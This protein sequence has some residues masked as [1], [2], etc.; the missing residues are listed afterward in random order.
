MV[1]T[2]TMAT[3]SDVPEFDPQRYPPF[4]SDIPTAP[5]KKISLAKLLS[6]DTAEIDAL[7]EACKTYGFFYLSTRDHPQGEALEQGSLN[8][9]RIAEET[10]KLPLEE[11]KKCSMQNTGTIFGYKH[12]GGSKTD[13]SGTLDTAEFMNTAKDSIINNASW[14]I[15]S[16]VKSNQHLFE[17]FV[18]TAHKTGLGILKLIGEKLGL[19][20]EEVTNRHRITQS[21]GDQVRMTRS[22]PLSAAAALEKQ[23]ATPAHTDFGSITLLFNWLGGLQIWEPE[24]PDGS[25]FWSSSRHSEKGEW[26]YVRPIPGYAICNL[27]DAMTR[28]S[29]GVLNSGKHRVLPAPGPQGEFVRYSIVYFVRPEDAVPLQV[30]KAEGIPPYEGKE[31][32]VVKTAGEHIVERARGLGVDTGNAKAVRSDV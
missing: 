21:S 7:F 19:P 30:L 10:F 15:P 22:P 18:T 13:A 27:G 12:A 23:I 6:K 2:R 25:K 11:K 29:N 5:I 1:G 9:A 31:D 14:P 8:M 26:K 24:D 17:P 20:E 4:P 32:E 28:F 16:T 3:V